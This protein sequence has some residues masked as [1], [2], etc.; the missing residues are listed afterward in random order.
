MFLRDL[1]IE[2]SDIAVLPPGYAARQFHDS[3]HAVVEAYLAALPRRK[4]KLANAAKIIVCVGPRPAAGIGAE[5]DFV[6]YPGGIVFIWLSGIGLDL[7][8]G[9]YVETGRAAQQQMLL[10]ALHGALLNVAS[11]TGDDI[12]ELQQA[13]QALLANGFPLPEISDQELRRRWR[14]LPTPARKRKSP[15]KRP[16]RNKRRKKGP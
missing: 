3:T 14:L 1:A 5:D 15:G 6:V 9:T 2:L 8:L 10:A 13:N 7:D 16:D 4:V 11:R 12:A